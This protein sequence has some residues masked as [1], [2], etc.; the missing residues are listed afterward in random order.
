MKFFKKIWIRIKSIFN[1]A[2][3]FLEQHVEQALMITGGIKRFL[4]SPAADILEA[5][6][7]GDIDKLVREKLLLATGAALKAMG[8]IDACK[9]LNDAD[10]LRCLVAELYK[11]QKEGKDAILFKL[12]A[13]IV[14]NMHGAKFPQSTYDL[15]TQGKYVERYK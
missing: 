15:L 3:D 6:I 7:P 9:G 4:E 1:R 13:L 12:A 10:K 11:L 8:V 2:D 14:K 5:V